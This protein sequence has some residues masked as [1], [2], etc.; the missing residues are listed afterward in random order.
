MTMGIT[1]LKKRSKGTVIMGC[2]TGEEINKLKATVQAKLGE[3]FRVAES[4]QIKSKIKI[5]NI[6]KEKIKLDADKL[7]ESESRTNLTR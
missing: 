6:D 7:I 5:I 3:N 1:K 4:P 2:E